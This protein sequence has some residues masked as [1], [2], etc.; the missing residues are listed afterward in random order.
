MKFDLQKLAVGQTQ[1]VRVAFWVSAFQ[2]RFDNLALLRFNLPFSPPPPQMAM[3][4][5]V[6]GFIF[7]WTEA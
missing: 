5:I 4:S 7:F 6:L 2:L 3:Y 1:L